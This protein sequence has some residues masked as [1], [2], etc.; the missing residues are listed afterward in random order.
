MSQSTQEPY[1]MSMFA[2]LSVADV[3]RSIEWYES[4]LGFEINYSMSM[5]ASVRYREHADLMLVDEK[6]S[7]HTD[8]SK[9]DTKRGQ[10]VSLYFIA[11]NESADEIAARAEEHDAEIAHGPEETTWNTREV[12]ISDPDGYELVFSE[13]LEKDGSIEEAMEAQDRSDSDGPSETMNTTSATAVPGHSPRSKG[14][15]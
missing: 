15:H 5:I 10:G 9:R 8:L 4:V 7:F 2:Q 11:E 6:T 1:P 3:E 12:V 13:R 14:Q